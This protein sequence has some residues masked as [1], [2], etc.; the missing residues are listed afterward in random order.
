VESDPSLLVAGL[1]ALLVIT[2]FLVSCETAFVALK[3][4]VWRYWEDERR[5]AGRTVAWLHRHRW[6]TLSTGA[7][8]SLVALFLAQRWALLLAAPAWGPEW[9]ALGSWLLLALVLIPLCMVPAY[10][11]AARSPERV[12]RWCALPL[13]VLTIVASPVTFALLT[14][15]RLF[16]LGFGVRASHLR[17]PLTEDELKAMLAES[18]E[19][20]TLPEPQRRMLYGVLSF[21]DQTAA[22]VMTPRPDIIS[23]CGDCALRVALTLALE[24]QHRRL[25]VYGEDDDDILGVLYLKDILPYLRSGDLDDPVRVATRPAFYVPEM[26][27]AADLL[28]QLQ[29]SRQTIAIVRD[30]YGGTAGLVTVEDLVE[31]IVGEIRDEYDTAEE[32]EIVRVCD[33]ELVCDGLVSLHPLEN[34]LHQDLP[35]EHYD[36]LAGFL[37]DLAGRIPSEGEHFT[38]RNLELVAERVRGN[39]VERVRLLQHP[40]PGEAAADDD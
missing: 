27:P 3:P 16:L 9:G 11:L 6:L 20:D 1:A 19:H 25:P 5:L 22:Q 2:G 18:E 28:R 39:R 30:E 31:Q 24:H 21:A 37:L 34:L 4:S 23:V 15:A 29:Q 7:A 26:L 40:L 33:S 14:L 8:G 35:D 12:S 38:W 32:P 13:F 17:A 10:Y 36:T